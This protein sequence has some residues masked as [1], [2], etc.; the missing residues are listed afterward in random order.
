MYRPQPSE[1][2]IKLYAM[3]SMPLVHDSEHALIATVNAMRQNLDDAIE[4]RMTIAYPHHM[5]ELYFTTYTL[6][7]LV[8]TPRQHRPPVLR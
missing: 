2:W 1:T 7:F 4:D 5:R 8:R 3:I 6:P